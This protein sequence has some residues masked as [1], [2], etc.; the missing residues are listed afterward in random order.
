LKGPDEKF[1]HECGAVIRARAEIC[2]GCGVRQPTEESERDQR[3]DYEPHRGTGILVLGVL[4]LFVMPLP[5]GLL[6]WFWGSEDLKKMNAGRM[7]PEGRGSTQAGKVCG[8]IS[9]LLSLSVF[10]IVGLYFLGV[11]FL[12]GTIS[13]WR[14]GGRGEPVAAPPAEYHSTPDRPNP[15]EVPRPE[16]GEEEEALKRKQRE[17]AEA[18]K[19]ARQEEAER[20]A[21]AEAER[22]AAA[23]EKKRREAEA[24]KAAQDEELASERLK[25]AKKLIDRGEA[26]VAKER[27]Q[28]I[29]KEFPN[30]KAA[31]E[32]KALLEKMSP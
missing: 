12:C 7:D 10:C 19:R 2:P 22:K 20:R 17:E 6:A 24:K 30:T 18:A 13:G 23:A 32:A 26:D 28:K 14:F 5:L 1:C 16:K 11:L 3:F 9:A 8:M 25:Y 15:A 21:A 4:S 31:A 27:L 29:V